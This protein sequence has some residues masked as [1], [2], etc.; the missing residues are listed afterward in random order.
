MLRLRLRPIERLRRLLRLRL[1]FFP[2][3]V[4]TPWMSYLFGARNHFAC[5][6]R[7]LLE[8]R[9]RYVR[10]AVFRKSAWRLDFVP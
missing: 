10:L 6:L 8:L 9:N 5:P 7:A 1:F 4:S 3:S 2:I